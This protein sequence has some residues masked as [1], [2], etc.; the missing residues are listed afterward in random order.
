MLEWEN[1]GSSRFSVGGG[2][3]NEGNKLL[4]STVY[5]W[6]PN[7]YR[8]I[9]CLTMLVY[10]AKHLP[11]ITRFLSQMESAFEHMQ[12]QTVGKSNR[13]FIDGY[14]HV[15][16]HCQF[17]GLNLSALYATEV[18]AKLR[19]ESIE[20]RKLADM[21]HILW[22]RITD[23]IDLRKFLYVSPAQQEFYEAKYLFGVEVET[24]FSRTTED[25]SEAGKCYA[26]ARYTASVFHLMR[27][28]EIGVQEL[29]KKLG[30][31]LVGEKVWQVILDQTNSVIR[32]M[33]AKTAAQKKKQAW[34]AEAS[35]HLFNVKLAWRNPVMHPKRT[36]TEE[37][38]KQLLVTVRSFMRH[39]A[40][41]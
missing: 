34:F 32:T 37:E 26:L 35:A 9:S 31:K 28:M 6:E 11:E 33:P 23:E 15:L 25:I 12:G 13:Q 10:G 2:A 7:R 17:L 38:A 29:G 40:G 18:V 41:A 27:V 36:Y 4:D 3:A 16:R 20:T 1:V 30:V 24:T 22:R 14:T 5:P 21:T 39:L 19:R 8:L